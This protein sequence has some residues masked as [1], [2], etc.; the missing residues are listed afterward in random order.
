MALNYGIL[1]EKLAM[2]RID[3]DEE[4]ISFVLEEAR[5]RK[6]ADVIAHV[7]EWFEN[8]NDIKRYL[9]LAQEAAEL[10]SGSSLRNSGESE[11]RRRR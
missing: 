3:I 4:E 10:G 7:A 5:K 1:I 11:E 6:D 9:E 8:R 2:G